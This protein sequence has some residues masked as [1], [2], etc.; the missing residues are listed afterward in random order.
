MAPAV[1]A[2]RKK[3]HFSPVTDWDLVRDPDS[4]DDFGDVPGILPADL[5]RLFQAFTV[6]AV[7]ATEWHWKSGW[8]IGPRSIHDSMWFYIAAGQGRGWV[9]HPGNAFVYEPGSLIFLSPDVEHFIDPTPGLKSHVFAVHFHARVFGAMDFLGVLGVPTICMSARDDSYNS[10]SFRLAREFALK[11]AGW[12]MV[13]S[14]EI[15]TVLFQAIRRAGRNLRPD[16]RLS[17]LP[18]MRR[19]LPVFQ[20]IEANLQLPELSVGELAG[21]AHLSEVQ[22]RKI[23]RRIT[24]NSPLRYVQRRRVERAC[25]MLHTSTESVTNIAEACGF[26]DAPF[27]H[28]VFKLWTGLTPGEY[29]NPDRP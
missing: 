29:R 10:A 9:G 23:F 21:L 14:A 28:R 8:K 11:K 15:R 4:F 24:G 2:D 25:E 17:S 6:D 27:F 19:L 3:P 13:M 16:A 7:S 5:D 22:L 18:D 12:K 20:H 26:A 1:P